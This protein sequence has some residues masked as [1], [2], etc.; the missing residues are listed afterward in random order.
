MTS[1]DSKFSRPAL[2]TTR[3]TILLGA[4]AAGAAIALGKMGSPA[5]AQQAT[6]VK[7]SEAIHLGIYVSV[8][9]AKFGGYFKK[10]GL[11]VAVSSAGGIAAALPVVLSGN[12][13]FAVTGTGMS[14][15]AATE[16]AKVVNVA[17][18]VGGMAM[19]AVAKPG[20]KL[21]T[22]EDFKGKTIAT[23]RFPSS[24][25]QV[26]SYIMKQKGGFDAEAAGVKFLQ[27]PPGAQ[28]QA[29]LDGRADFASMFE[30]DASIAKQQ[31]GLEPVLS[32]GDFIEPAA[33]T[34]A[35]MPKAAVEK[36]PAM[37]QAFCDALA[38]TQVALHADRELFVKTSMAE[39]P[40]VNEAVI[41]SAADNLLLKTQA[42]PKAPTISKAE[43]D[44]DI[45]FEIAGGSIKAGR[46]YEEMVDNTFATKAATKFGKAG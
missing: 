43:W 3:R 38:E 24:T 27:L 34:T 19:W 4:G 9:A 26:P 7:V 46:P 12:A 8:Y 18:I 40:Q 32:L 35:I 45:A 15:N 16:G 13:T 28:A 17:K 42:I 37:V 20:T 30:W 6:A 14:V 22:I 44:A 2:I 33:F 31:F 25:M 10:H 11:D 23:L 41:R 1:R 29:V 39:F 36:D 21:K 5:F